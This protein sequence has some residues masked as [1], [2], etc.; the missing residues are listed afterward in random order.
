MSSTERGYAFATWAFRFAHKVR[1]NFRHLQA[2]AV[3]AVDVSP[4][5]VL[6]SKQVRLITGTR[7]GPVPSSAPCDGKQTQL[8]D[9]CSNTNVSAYSLPNQEPLLCQ[10]YESLRRRMK[11][12]VMR[13]LVDNLK[14]LRGMRPRVVKHLPHTYSHLMKEQSTTVSPD[15]NTL[16]FPAPSP[17]ACVCGR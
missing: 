10:T 9:F 17:Q 12:I 2:P 15:T 5:S 4:Y 11:V 6:P 13:I 3:K 7:S 16:P 1:V 8:L 14:A